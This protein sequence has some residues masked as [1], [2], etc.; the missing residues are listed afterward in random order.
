[1]KWA[2]HIIR[3]IEFDKVEKELREFDNTD[4]ARKQDET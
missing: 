4:K 3:D 2:K 1:M